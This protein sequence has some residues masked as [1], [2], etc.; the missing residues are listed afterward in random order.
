MNT[1]PQVSLSSTRRYAF[2]DE[3]QVRLLHKGSAAVLPDDS[4]A[5]QC[6]GV[7][8]DFALRR[9]HYSHGCT[10]CM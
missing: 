7:D 10:C 8:A 5:T 3:A 6:A 4:I 2:T 9:V 1:F